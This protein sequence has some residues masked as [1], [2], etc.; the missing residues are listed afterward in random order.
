[1]KQT[2]KI[3]NKSVA[4]KVFLRQEAT[5]HLAGLSVL[6]LYAANNVLWRN[7]DKE[8]YYSVDIAPQKGKNLCADAKQVVRSLDLHDFNVID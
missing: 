7:F 3:E 2:I 1:M 8:R 6:D 4:N 5:R